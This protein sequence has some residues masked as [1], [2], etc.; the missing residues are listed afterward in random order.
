V[1]LVYVYVMAW[2]LG[3]VVLGGRL[4]LA[5]REPEAL[6]LS[7][8]PLVRASARKAHVASL[9]AIALVAFGLSGLMAEGFGYLTAPWTL[10]FAGGLAALVAS[11]GHALTRTRPAADVAH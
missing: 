5:H 11:A 9:V 8:S 6:A 7:G 3:G 1:G 2:V 10:A 4:L